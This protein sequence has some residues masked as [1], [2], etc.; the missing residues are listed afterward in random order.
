MRRFLRWAARLGAF[1]QRGPQLDR[2]GVAAATRAIERRSCLER[3]RRELAGLERKWAPDGVSR[4]ATRA[5]GPSPDDRASP[6]EQE[7]PAALPLEQGELV[8]VA[9]VLDAPSTPDRAAS[10]WARAARQVCACRVLGPG[11]L[12]ERFRPPKEIGAA[13]MR[14]FGPFRASATMPSWSRC[15]TYWRLPTTSS[16]G[17]SAIPTMPPTRTTSSPRSTRRDSGQ[18]ADPYE[19]R[20]AARQSGGEERCSGGRARHLRHAA[21]RSRGQGRERTA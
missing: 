18:D 4:G 9:N 5:P 16:D 2:H 17:A 1:P 12:E 8:T 15:P 10:A 11:E 7:R 3:A 21:L 13:S 14:R 20:R 19:E 6:A